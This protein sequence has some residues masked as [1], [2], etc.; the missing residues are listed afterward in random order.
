ME[1]PNPISTNPIIKAIMI[2]QMLRRAI[3]IPTA[4][5]ANITQMANRNLEI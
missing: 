1:M 3:P 5:N 2:N 4:E